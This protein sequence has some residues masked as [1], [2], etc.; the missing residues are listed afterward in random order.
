MDIQKRYSEWESNCS[1]DCE[2][3]EIGDVLEMI[4]YEDLEPQIRK[5]VFLEGKARNKIVNE[6][7]GKIY[8]IL[9]DPKSRKGIIINADMGAIASFI[10]EGN[11]I[12]M[13][14]TY[15]SG[16]RFIEM[17]YVFN[18]NLWKNLEGEE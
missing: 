8:F 5:K 11:D 13:T 17:D 2:K 10:E 4:T 14:G 6:H 1:K 12:A 15:I 18:W 3:M 16:R 7:D 9:E